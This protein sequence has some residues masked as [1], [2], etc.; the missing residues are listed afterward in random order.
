[1]IAY[2]RR[3]ECI[4]LTPIICQSCALC[5]MG[6]AHLHIYEFPSDV[7]SSLSESVLHQHLER[8]LSRKRPDRAK[9]PVFPFI[10]LSYQTHAPLLK[11]LLAVYV[12]DI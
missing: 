7:D 12:G 10:D 6:E 5:K 2:A 3:A 9:A 8:N 11:M 1:M 4:T